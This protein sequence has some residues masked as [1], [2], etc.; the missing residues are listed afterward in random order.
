MTCDHCVLKESDSCNFCTMNPKATNHFKSEND[1]YPLE[2]SG[3]HIHLWEPHGSSKCTI[4]MF[5][6]NRSEES[7]DL[8]FIGER[9]L[10]ERVDK[11]KFF[12]LIQIGFNNLRNKEEA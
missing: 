2:L 4:A 12:E 6:Y 3:Y 1:F 7:W 9:P 11:I 8:D 5:N 10:D